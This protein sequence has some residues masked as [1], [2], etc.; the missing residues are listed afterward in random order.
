MSHS[1]DADRQ[2]NRVYRL[3]LIED[4]PVFRLGL[5]ACLQSFDDLQVVLE[6]DSPARA[7]QL[8]RE[9]R[10]ELE[11]TDQPVAPARSLDLIILNL[12]LGLTTASQGLGLALCQQLRTQYGDTPL[13]LLGATLELTRLAAAF[14]SVPVATA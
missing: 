11:A 9:W 8:L 12:D 2:Q 13:L 6:A 1:H 4:D 3:M 5:A 7:L 10:D 14:Q